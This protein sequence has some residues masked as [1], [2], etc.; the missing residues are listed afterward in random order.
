MCGAAY[1]WVCDDE[2]I[3][4]SRWSA[5]GARRR[6]LCIRTLVPWT[7]WRERADRAFVFVCGYQEVLGQAVHGYRV[8]RA[9]SCIVSTRIKQYLSGRRTLGV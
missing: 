4:V 1:T 5:C 2:R 6:D 7:A 9:G 3:D 8:D